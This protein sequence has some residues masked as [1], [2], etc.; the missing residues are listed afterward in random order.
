MRR[1]IDEVIAYQQGR[2]VEKELQRRIEQVQVFV[3]GHNVLLC[4]ARS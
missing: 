2:S 4:N 3:Q 1:Q